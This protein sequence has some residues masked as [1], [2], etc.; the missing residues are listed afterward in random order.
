MKCTDKVS[1]QQI[2][3]EVKQKDLAAK[4]KARHFWTL[5]KEILQIN[6]Q[7]VCSLPLTR[8]ETEEA[9]HNLPMLDKCRKLL[10]W[11]SGHYNVQYKLAVI[12]FGRQ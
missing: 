4:V 7:Q 6:N 2:L 8:D 3:N 5:T 1:N 9:D 10:E 12:S 11:V